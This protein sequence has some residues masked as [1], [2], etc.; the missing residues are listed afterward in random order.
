MHNNASL[1]MNK[2]KHEDKGLA[3][4]LDSSSAGH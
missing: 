3:V 2:E 4:R 1:Y